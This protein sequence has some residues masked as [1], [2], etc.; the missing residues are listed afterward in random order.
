MNQLLTGPGFEMAT[1]RMLSENVTPESSYSLI[2][3]RKEIRAQKTGYTML[4]LQSMT[5]D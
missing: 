5:S 3:T 2:S 4:Q 1:F